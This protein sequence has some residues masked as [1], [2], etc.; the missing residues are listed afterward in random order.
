MCVCVCVFVCV[1]WLV[2]DRS[3]TGPISNSRVVE[4]F[5]RVIHEFN[6]WFNCQAEY[7]ARQCIP[8]LLLFGYGYGSKLNHQGTAG[9]KSFVPFYQGSILGTLF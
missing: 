4:N 1:F 9:F 6:P 8:R 5:G 3:G 7:L 2:G